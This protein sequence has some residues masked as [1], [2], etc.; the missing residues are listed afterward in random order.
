MEPMDSQGE[1]IIGFDFIMA[2]L[3]NSSQLRSIDFDFITIPPKDWSKH[4]KKR[5]MVGFHNGSVKRSTSN[6]KTNIQV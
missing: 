4:Q 3:R 1:Q 2:P 5:Y 6:T